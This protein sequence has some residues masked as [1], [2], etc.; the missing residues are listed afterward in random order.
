MVLYFVEP[1]FAANV[2]FLKYLSVASFMEAFS[3][4]CVNY[5]EK[6]QRVS[7]HV[8]FALIWHNRCGLGHGHIEPLGFFP[9]PQS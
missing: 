1:P 4:S 3:S 7:V 6:Q 9:I 8:F 2:S 5:E